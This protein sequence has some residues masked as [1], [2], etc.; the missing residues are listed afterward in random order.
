[1]NQV[2]DKTGPAAGVADRPAPNDGHEALRIRARA[3]IDGDF[4]GV[5]ARAARDADVASSTFSAW[6]GGTYPGDRAQVARKVEQWLA[7]REERRAVRSAVPEAPTFLMTPTARGILQICTQAQTT[8]DFA[9]VAGVSGVG[10]TSALREY[11]VTRRHVWMVTAHRLVRSPHGL[12]EQIG[13]GAGVTER[14]AS[15]LFDA[16]VVRLQD[17]GGLVIVDE[18][19]QLTTEALDQLRA[20]HDLAGVGVVVSGNIETGTRL[21]GAGANPEFAPLARRVG[22]RRTWTRSLPGDIEALLDAWGITDKR[23]REY[24]AA[25]AGRSGALGAITKTVQL[26]ALVADGPV[27]LAHLRA[28]RAQLVNGGVS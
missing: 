7:A 25:E 21:T 14:G 2:I 28:A 26:A 15:R 11:A 8:V 22:V 23:S 16:L 4:S 17:R 5:M 1:M 27:E 6:M 19:H 3:V 18:A 13:R 24:L 12:M 9:I 10:K 20:L